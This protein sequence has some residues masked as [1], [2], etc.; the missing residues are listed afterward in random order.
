MVVKNYDTPLTIVGG[1]EFS[2]TNFHKCL[3]IA[4]KIIAVDSGLNFLNINKNV[5]DWIIGDL[6]SVKNLKVWKQKGSNIKKIA[7][8]ETTDFEKCLYS[9]NAPFFLGNAF[10]GERIDHS[11]AAISSL[12]KMK[13]KKVFL[14]GKRD[15][16]FHINK[17]IE[18]NLE[19]GTRI[20]LF[21]LKDV[22][23]IS[24]E[25]LRYRIKGVSF[26]P[27]FKIGTSNEVLH[28]KVKIELSGT[29]MIII[30][31]IKSF[32]KIVKFM[33]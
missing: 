10:L 9:F 33:N 25:G 13:D 26:S 30:L 27:G 17:K 31:P 15:F 24:S 16:L 22:V 12:V 3:K 7:E 8:Q 11:M 20:S 14:L 1:G 21:P 28:S 29:G 6:D 2:S 4:P 5:P 19:I 23:G 32:D 18:L